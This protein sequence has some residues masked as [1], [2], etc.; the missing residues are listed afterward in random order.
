M[1]RSPYD[2]LHQ[3]YDAWFDRYPCV[4]DAELRAIRAVLPVG[5]GVE[6]GVGSGRFA[7]PLKVALG[8]DP[9]RGMLTRAMARGVAVGEGRA[10]ALPIRSGSLDYL[11]LVTVLCFLA[12]PLKALR[13]ARRVLKTGGRAVIAFIDRETPLGRVYAEHQHESAFYRDARFYSAEE[14]LTLFRQAGFTDFIVHQTIFGPLNEIGPNEPV[15]A[16]WGQG[17]FV[18]VAGSDQSL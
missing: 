16:G 1:N 13:E 10:E 14:A 8:L 3:E 7:A 18:V 17:A 11:L 6:V 15:R 12:E 5:V 2:A 9:S 4:Y